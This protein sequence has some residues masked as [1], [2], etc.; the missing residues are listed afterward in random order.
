[1]QGQLIFFSSGASLVYGC[2]HCDLA[3][4]V[5]TYQCAAAMVRAR[6]LTISL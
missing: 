1:M 6:I 4:F 3:K 2:Y 5:I